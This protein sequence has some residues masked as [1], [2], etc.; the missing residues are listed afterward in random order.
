MARFDLTEAAEEDLL[1]IWDYLAGDSPVAADRV[2]DQIY[3]ALQFLGDNPGVGHCW[4]EL[5]DRSH[6]FFGVF[7]YLVIYLNLGE[8]IQVVRILHGARDVLRVLQ[9]GQA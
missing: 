7:S 4:E 3:K 5:A 6:R 8:K 2:L 1:A 9:E